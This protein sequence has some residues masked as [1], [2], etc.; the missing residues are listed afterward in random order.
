MKIIA[1]TI[2]YSAVGYVVMII[3]AKLFWF[4]Y[5]YPDSP[6]QEEINLVW[7][8]HVLAE[9][10]LGYLIIIVLSI[11]LVFNFKQQYGVKSIYLAIFAGITYNVIGGLI[12][13][14]RF[15]YE[16][17]FKHSLPLQLFGLV[18]IICGLTSL[19]AYK[20]LPNKRLK[21]CGC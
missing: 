12:W 11:L 20:Y 16:P 5:P 9:K 10:L 6:T 13:I 8:L 2:G 15:G 4:I 17:Y 14:V 19:F 3:L 18:I 7:S 1:K 21:Q